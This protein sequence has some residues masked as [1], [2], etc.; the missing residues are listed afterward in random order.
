[1]MFSLSTSDELGFISVPK[2]GQATCY[3]GAGNSIDCTGTG[4]DGEHR[5]GISWPDPRFKDNGNGTIT[6]SLTGLMWT[7]SA[8]QIKGTMKWID[9]LSTCNNLDFAGYTDWRLPNVIELTSLIDY[10]EHDP[11]LP[12]GHP[13]DNV[14]F[15]FYWTSTTYDSNTDHAWGVYVYNGYVYNYHKITKAYV[16]PVRGGI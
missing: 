2:T 16:W 10:S 14:Q 15:I 7:K 13:F 11:A 9:A 3:D 1:M 6:D 8:Q 12:I 4:Q 5:K